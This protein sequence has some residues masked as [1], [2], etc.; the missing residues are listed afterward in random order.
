[1]IPPVI[2][3]QS[4]IVSSAFGQENFRLPKDVINMFQND[5]QFCGRAIENLN[6]HNQVFEDLSEVIRLRLFPY[7][8][9]DLAREWLDTFPLQSIT[10]WNQL[11]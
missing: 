2:E 11:S 3:S 6:A 1:M 8:L 4:S 9:L 5:L 10:T 7:S